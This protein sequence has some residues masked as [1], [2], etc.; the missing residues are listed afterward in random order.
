VVNERLNVARDEVDRLKAV[1]TNCVRLGP[2]SQNREGI[3]AFRE[4]L[5]GRVGFVESVNAG[6]GTKLRKIFEGIV[7]G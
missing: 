6:R 4:H 3:A 7:W 1:L 2:V 5:R